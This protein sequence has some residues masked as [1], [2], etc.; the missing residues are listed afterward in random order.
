[1]RGSQHSDRNFIDTPL[2]GIAVTPNF[3]LDAVIP[4]PDIIGL[5]GGDGYLD[6]LPTADGAMVVGQTVLLSFGTPPYGSTWQLFESTE[7][8]NV[9]E[10]RVRPTD[11]N[12]STNPRVWFQ[13]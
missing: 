10:G 4:L 2:P 1:M 5:E 3:E 12:A 7:T 9:S 8:T 6:G 11:Y 13:L